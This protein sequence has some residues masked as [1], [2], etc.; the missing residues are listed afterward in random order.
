MKVVTGGVR[1]R[2]RGVRKRY[3]DESYLI[4]EYIFFFLLLFLLS[5]YPIKL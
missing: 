2:D 4:N 1:L 3:A 5:K